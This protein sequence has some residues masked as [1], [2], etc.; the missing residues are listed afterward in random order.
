MGEHIGAMETYA[1]LAMKAQCQ[2]RTTAE[3][4][5]PPVVFARQANISNG[6]QQLNNGVPAGDAERAAQAHAG[7]DNIVP[8]RTIA[9]ATRQPCH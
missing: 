5:N 6:P 3:M 9:D 4:K 1:R 2:C 7:E 8:D